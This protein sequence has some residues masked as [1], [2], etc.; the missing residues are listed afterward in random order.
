MHNVIPTFFICSLSFVTE[1]KLTSVNGKENNMEEIMENEV[2][3]EEKTF[4][5]EEVNR[6]IK[7]R[8]ARLKAKYET[9]TETTEEESQ[10]DEREKSITLRENRVTCM[11]YVVENG[12]KKE[13]LDILD[14]SD[15]ERFRSQA[16]KIVELYGEPEQ[17]KVYPG[18]KQNPVSIRPEK[19]NSFPNV[20][21]TPKQ[22]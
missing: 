4:T 12:H 20:K 5:Q 19:T 14:T 6:I 1:K 18:T 2:T 7:D 11:E 9:D 21:H 3:T 17:K 13:L 10:L 22:Y 8:L 15:P 16:E